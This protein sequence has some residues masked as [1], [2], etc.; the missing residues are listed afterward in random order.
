[1]KSQAKPQSRTHSWLYRDLMCHSIA[2]FILGF[3]LLAQAQSPGDL[4]TSF[5]PGSGA[6][7]RV[8]GIARQ[9]D[10]K[11]VVGGQFT[12]FNDQKRNRITRLNE[13]GS[14]DFTFN[15]GDG[16]DSSV[17]AVAIAPDGKILVGG[18]F[19]SFNGASR[20]RLVRL[21]ASGSVDTSFV[22]APGADGTVQAITVQADGKV[23][24]AGSFTAV[25]GTARNRVARLNT[26]G[27]LDASFNPGFGP[28]G[29][30]LTITQ[31]TDGNILIGGYFASVNGTTRNRVARLNNDGTLDPG[32]VPGTL[33][34][35]YVNSVS[36]TAD[37]KV[38]IA[39]GISVGLQSRILRLLA[40]GAVDNTFS[41]G[42]N[43]ISSDVTTAIAQSDGKVLIGGHFESVTG[44]S[45]NGI[46]RLNS[47]GSLDPAFNPGA[48]ANQ[49]VWT[50]LLQPDGRLVAGGAFTTYAG[51]SRNRITRIHNDAVQVNQAPLMAAIGSLTVLEDAGPQNV[52]VAGIAPGPAGEA[53]QMVTNLTAT[54]SNPAIIPHPSVSYTPGAT[55]TSLAFTPVANANGVVTISVVAQDNGGTAFGG[56]DKTTNT[57]TVT[58][59]PVNDAPGFT[60]APAGRVVAWFTDSYL[61]M[62]QTT[63]PPAALSGVTAVAG[64]W[65]HSLALKSDGSVVAWGDNWRG[66]TNV[67]AAAQSGVVAVAAGNSFSLA[68]KSDGTVVAW[69]NNDN[70]ETDVPPDLTSVVA[71]AAGENHSLALK[72]DG[73]VVAWGRN[74][75]WPGV[76]PTNVPPGLSNVVAIAAGSGNSLALKSDGT[77]VGWGGDWGRF[78]GVS[79][80]VAIDAF[81][82]R[83]LGLKRDGTLAE[84]GYYGLGDGT[85]SNVTAIAAGADQALALRSD[86]TVL[87]FNGGEIPLAAQR[88]VMAISAGESHSLAVVR[89]VSP[90]LVVRE[91][92]GAQLVEGALNSISPGP[93][94]ESAQIVTFTVTNDNNA[95]FLVQPGISTGGTLTF[96]PAPNANG[97]ATVT[98]IARDNGGLPG[99]DASAPQTFTLTVTPVNDAPT[100]AFATNNV[101]VAE[102]SAGYSGGMATVSVGPANESGQSVTSVVTSNDN[103]ALFSV[104]PLVSLGGTLTFTLATNATGIA[105][106]TV[107]AQDNGG[108][109]DDGVD[110]ITNTFALTVTPVNDAPFLVLQPRPTA[111]AYFAD[112]SFVYGNLQG[113][114]LL[115][116]L[117]VT[118]VPFTDFASVV[119]A[120]PVI[121]V[122][123]MH[124]PLAPSLSV[125]ALASISNFVHTGGVLVVMGNHIPLVQS[126]D[127][128]N[129]VFGY[130]L[131][132]YRLLAVS[133]QAATAAGTPFADDPPW[134]WANDQQS[135]AISSLP[136]N[137]RVIYQREGVGW[138]EASVTVFPVGSGRAVTLGGQFGQE[139]SW[140]GDGSWLPV[141]ASAITPVQQVEVVN[142]DAGPQSIAGFTS[143]TRAGPTNESSQIVSITVTNDNNALFLMQPGI[144]TS[145]TLT[146]TPAPN[147]SGSAN[148]TIIARD[149]GGL[150]GVDTSAPQTFTITVTPVNDAPVLAAIGVSGTEDT[151]LTFAAVNFT[152]AYSD[153]EGTPLASLTVVTL[154]ATGILKLSG[155]DVTPGQV[156]PAA[157]LGNLTYVPVANDHGAKTF[158]VT[159]SDGSL[160]SAAATVTMTVTPVND[161]PGFSLSPS[162]REGIVVAWGKNNYG[163]ITVPGAPLRAVGL[164]AN[165]DHTLALKAD[166]TVVAWGR[167]D[168]GQATVPG[169]LNS[170]VAVVAG[171]DHSLALKSDGTVVA[172][173]RNQLGQA[174]VP[175]GLNRVVAISAGVYHN[176]ALRN[177]GTVVAWGANNVGQ[178]TVPPGLNGVVAVEAGHEFSLA[179]LNDGT[180]VAWG[181]NTYHETEVPAG[182]SNVVAIAAGGQHALALKSDGTVVAWGR[183]TFGSGNTG[184]GL[185]EV[186][187]GLAGVMAITA[188]GE[189]NLALKADGTV[190]AWGRNQEGQT[191]VPVGLSGVV[192]VSAG[193]YHSVALADATGSPQVTVLEDAGPQTLVGMARNISAGLS[194]AA[195]QAISFNVTNDNNALFLVQP[196]IAANGTLTFTPATNANGSAIVTVIAVD[197]G[198]APGV[199]NSAPQTFTII[200]TPVNDAPSFSLSSMNVT[201]F[202]GDGGVVVRPNWVMNR[203]A[204][205]ANEAGQTI[206]FERTNS[207]P[208]LFIDQPVLLA[209]GT[210]E[211]TPEPTASGVITVG[212]RVVDNGG[213]AN[214][215]A[216]TSGWQTFTITFAS[217]KIFV[218]ESPTVI[219]GTTVE[220]PI[221]LAGIGNEG[222]LSFTVTYDRPRLVFMSMAVEPGSGLTLNWSEPYGGMMNNVGIIVTK[223]AGSNFTAGTNVMVRLSFQ[224]PIG[225]A[226]TN[227]PISFSSAVIM[228]Q[229]S[230]T[231]ASAIRHVSYV[232]GSVTII[233]V[234]PLE[235]D[236]A[237]R[238]TGSGAVTVSDA[239]QLTR[240]VAGWD[241]ITDFAA[242]GEFQRA[243][244]APRGTLG[245]GRVTLID[246]VQTLRY[247]AGLDPATPAGG[248]TLQAASLAASSTRMSAGSRVVRVAGGNLVAGRANTVSIQLDAQG[249]EAGVI[250]SLSF[251][252][253]VMTFVNATV[254]S[255][256]NG[257]SLMVN[258]AKAAAGRVGLVLVMPAG[259]GI[260]AGTRDIIT[261][262]FNVTGTG[263]TAISVT[264][265]SPVA[266]EVAD[267]SANVLGAS[268]VGGSFNL[269]LPPGLKAA[270]LERA[271]DGSLR[272][273]VVNSDGTPV[274]A[275]RA[276][277]Y[278]VHVTSDLGGAWTLLSNALVIE[279]GALKIVDPAAN[280][281][282]LRLYKLVESF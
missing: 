77:V 48:G 193:Y 62:G 12:I 211:F 170:V 200:V 184:T 137:A 149:N 104:Q 45:R 172:W 190:V 204:G 158:T 53:A 229:V 238:T 94:N 15:A 201:V 245:D 112:T 7:W 119:G 76:G 133:T 221:S 140:S 189:H 220:V 49:L 176:L 165:A 88:G 188:N 64:G 277:R 177:D 155:V 233:A 127:L 29:A 93:A 274:T 207:N 281:A 107:I 157:G 18:D 215:G 213:T 262:T 41:P 80:L 50:L 148:V 257:G 22:L 11:L 74:G 102:D 32:F 4:D 139:F 144:S 278:E 227:T 42:N 282:G 130:S 78:T 129:A 65:Y 163:Q 81:D 179:L 56:V 59:T 223:P 143:P 40:N 246:L 3:G 214:G 219:A 122:P 171:G 187:V 46:A 2:A 123:S 237:P 83:T 279:N 166:A 174:D 242:N 20:Y 96:T 58:V 9:T 111:V 54:S 90:A 60:L 10:G 135:Y 101:V 250:L 267:V 236:V 152:E 34:N 37:G 151:A 259:S 14:T 26:D 16:A 72:N 79:D 75:G 142:E 232:P 270:G 269:I 235:G 134:L 180:V 13:N 248:P 115:T 124:T 55:T 1:M 109:A 210:L 116:N 63:V 110:T 43:A 272:L 198:G 67:P 106:V 222:G 114:T 206:T 266:R 30:V 191:S 136:P 185:S 73:T 251:D 47:D 263:S 132:P 243:D 126:A 84:H 57:F 138:N 271:A 24:I 167:N 231:N 230:D 38:F 86:G 125:A 92:S 131:V 244:C 178:A 118:V 276:A 141:L 147:A 68:L 209:D 154:P 186:P 103:N 31:Q 70:Q 39:G 69:G 82:E 275:E 61:D 89:G 255:G 258:N 33:D 23:L 25:N 66:Q 228:Q 225:T 240:F 173:G 17:N 146:F 234:P 212:V 19:Y 117:G 160:S 71:I 8:L 52:N 21:N 99:A 28:N 164:S 194:E 153:V 36:L 51:V 192:A 95:L 256:A 249:N 265:D 273:V 241:V 182:L 145:G 181:E 205:P 121:V 195:S 175:A 156:I 162:G 161:A 44:V 183:N 196:A 105:T 252:P 97:S 268:F 199:S 254:G 218:S 5:N 224:A 6:D 150:P 108:T 239:V 168:F 35:G 87:A 128:L 202:P 169:G 85:V 253:T 159:A 197:N 280:G 113:G 247:A 208:A 260:A 217:V 100:I 203:S 216:D 264:G 98:V 91:D 120:Y 226:P 27:S 261:L